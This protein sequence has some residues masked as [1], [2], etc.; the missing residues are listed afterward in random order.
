MHITGQLLLLLVL[1]L[2]LGQICD[3][4][5]IATAIVA[6]TANH[7]HLNQNADIDATSELKLDIFVSVPFQKVNIGDMITLQVNLERTVEGAI[8]AATSFGADNYVF[9]GKADEGKIER[10][11][12]RI[13]KP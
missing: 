11:N 5:V 13:L 10:V 4:A 3:T 12:Q 9:S 1:L 2:A 7:V 6:Q 8:T